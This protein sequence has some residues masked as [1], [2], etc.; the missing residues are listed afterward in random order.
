MEIAYQE[1]SE[2]DFPELL[3]MMA[4]FYAFFSYPFDRD[5]ASRNLNELA[6][7]KNLGRIWRFV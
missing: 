2:S 3:L 1:P 7:N 4:D 6:G 5:S